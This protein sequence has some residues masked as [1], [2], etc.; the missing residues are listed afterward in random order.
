MLVFGLETTFQSLRRSR[1]PSRNRWQTPSALVIIAMMVFAAWAATNVFPTKGKCLTG[2]VWW[3]AR[4]AKLAVVLASGLLA[5]Y[6]VS[7]VIITIQLVRTIKVDKAERI[8][9]TRVVY[10]LVVNTWLIVSL[11]PVNHVATADQI[12]ALILPYYIQILTGKS[13]MTTAQIAEVAINLTGIVNLIMHILLRSNADRLAIRSIETPWTDKRT[14]RVFGPSDL[15]IREHISYPV[16]WQEGDQDHRSSIAK[17][18]NASQRSPTDSDCEAYSSSGPLQHVVFPSPES[19]SMKAL[20]PPS[21][22]KPVRQFTESSASYRIFPNPH[23]AIA[24]MSSSTTFSDLTDRVSLP[25]PPKPLFAAKHDRNISSQSG[26]T[27][28]IGLRL[29]Y[30]NHAL[31]PIEASPSIIGLPLP[32][33]GAEDSNRNIETGSDMHR[34]STP[35]ETLTDFTILPMHSSSQIPESVEAHNNIPSADRAPPP[36]GPVQQ[37]EMLTPHI[38]KAARVGPKFTEAPSKLRGSMKQRSPAQDHGLRPALPI[39]PAT[40]PPSAIL[41]QRIIRPQVRIDTRVDSDNRATRH[42]P[43]A[44][45][46]TARSSS[47]TSSEPS[48]LR[49]GP[50]PAPSWRPQNWNRTKS[51]APISPKTKTDENRMLSGQ[52][53][54][55]VIPTRAQYDPRTP[56]F[57]NPFIV[58]KPQVIL[59]PPGWI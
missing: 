56:E 57:I 6:P 41:S 46:A 43:I 40:Q 10:Y 1:F 13:A 25:L 26:E 22:T 30:M 37:P 24:H 16:L 18:E 51:N 31:D 49:T 7:A 3:T 55:P 23:S 29:S 11:P 17:P 47:L 48:S 32:S 15:N 35:S 28:Q 8:A 53:M 21:K 14:M 38:L 20:T 50:K 44:N 58:A 59:R 39:Q 36:I 5:L 52:K 12:Q 19:K 9:A 34:A 45:Q 27:V 33:Q 54:L 4:Y 42:Q 2:L